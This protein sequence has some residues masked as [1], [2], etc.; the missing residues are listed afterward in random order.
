MFA[1]NIFVQI[2]SYRLVLGIYHSHIYRT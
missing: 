1:T 2:P